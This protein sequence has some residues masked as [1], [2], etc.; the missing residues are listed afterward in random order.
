MVVATCIAGGC[1]LYEMLAGEAPYTGPSAQAIVAK[2]LREPVPHV[3]TVRETV[4][5]SVEAAPERVLAK[6]PADRYPV[7]GVL[8]PLS[9]PPSRPVRYRE[10]ERPRQE[11]TGARLSSNG[12]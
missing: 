2:R 1:V 5:A 12:R 8:L 7:K 10:A 6:A 3:R 9:R 4:P 11:V